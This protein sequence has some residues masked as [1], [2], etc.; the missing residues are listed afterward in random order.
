MNTK[1]TLRMDDAIIRKAKIEAKNR[2]KS[3]SRMVAEFLESISSPSNQET[4]LPPTTAS[5]LGILKDKS[6]SEDDYK[7]HLRE[8]HL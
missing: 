3:L 7:A 6:I 1:L 2:G 4:H 8:K 5:L